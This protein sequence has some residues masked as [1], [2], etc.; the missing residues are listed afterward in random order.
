MKYKV[1][2]HEPA[3]L[4]VQLSLRC[5]FWIRVLILKQ[6][7]SKSRLQGLHITW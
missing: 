5:T 6:R 1:K 4:N 3:L 2:Y 7:S